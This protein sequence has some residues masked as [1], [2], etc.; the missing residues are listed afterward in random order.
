M[1][2]YAKEIDK[3]KEYAYLPEVAQKL[4][5]MEQSVD[6]FNAK[7]FQT[8]F[9]E[10]VKGLISAANEAMQQAKFLLQSNPTL[11]MEFFTTAKSN[12]GKLADERFV[13]VPAVVTFFAEWKDKVQGFADQYNAVLFG[14]EV[15]LLELGKLIMS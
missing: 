13:A 9:A 10:E 7:C 2:T 15:K 12:A 11:A 5:S 14:A 8:I 4:T 6:E 3:L 1:W